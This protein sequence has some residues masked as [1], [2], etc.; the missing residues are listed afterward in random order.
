VAFDG[1]NIWVT[2]F[3]ANT[4]IKVLANGAVASTYSVGRNRISARNPES[5]GVQGRKIPCDPS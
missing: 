1:S 3:G 5:S 2:N 4:V